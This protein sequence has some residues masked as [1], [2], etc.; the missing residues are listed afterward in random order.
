MRAKAL[1]TLLCQL[2]RG[3]GSLIRRRNLFSCGKAAPI[4]KETNIMSF[5]ARRCTANSQICRHQTCVKGAGRAHLELAYARCTGGECPT[6]NL[7]SRF[8]RLLP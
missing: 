6:R 3:N 8:R 2:L 4:V 7:V 1:G 5:R